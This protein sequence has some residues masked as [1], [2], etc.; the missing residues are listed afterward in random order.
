MSE[1]VPLNVIVARRNGQDK[2]RQQQNGKQA[3]Q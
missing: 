2:N 3:R 1:F